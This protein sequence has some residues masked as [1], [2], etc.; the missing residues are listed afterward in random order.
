MRLNEGTIVNKT[1]VEETVCLMT[2]TYFST[3]TLYNHSA[4]SWIRKEPISLSDFTARPVLLE[5][6]EPVKN[7]QVLDLG[8]GEGYCSRELKRRGAAKVYGIDLSERMIEAAQQQDQLDNLEIKYE[9]KCA[10][11][12]AHIGSQSFDQVLAVFLFNYLTVEQMTQCMREVFRVLRPGGRF[13]FSVPHPAFP[14][15]RSEEYPFYFDVGNLGYFSQRNQQFPGKIWKRDGS[16]LEVQLV[17]KP[18]EDYFA[19]LADA[20]FSVMPLVRELRVT[21]EHLQIDSDFF[22]PLFDYPLHLAIQISR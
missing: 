21:S 18:L 10:T 2:T 20:G 3:K 15:M 9:A 6:C 16:W 12:L 5:M 4:G 22:K 19:A 8:C 17:H 14:Y 11:N 7:L 13:V 1:F